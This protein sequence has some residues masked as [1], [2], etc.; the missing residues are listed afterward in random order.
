MPPGSPVVTYRHSRFTRGGGGTWCCGAWCGGGRPLNL[1]SHPGRRTWVCR[2]SPI[3]ALHIG[4]VPGAPPSFR[5]YVAR[6]AL[7]CIATRCAA[8]GPTN[9]VT[10]SNTSAPCARCPRKPAARRGLVLGTSARRP[11]SSVHARRCT[12]C[13]RPCAPRVGAARPCAGCSRRPWPGNTSTRCTG[14]RAR[15]VS[16]WPQ[17]IRCGWASLHRT[18]SLDCGRCSTRCA[19][20][21]S[22][23]PTAFGGSTPTIRW[24]RRIEPHG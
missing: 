17:Q 16:T 5:S 11:A 6:G 7:A 20:I 15:H 24:S 23:P 21:A 4:L 14:Q 13:A 2:S 10:A 18:S 22:I 19:S 8:N 3:L 12:L 9:T 1:L